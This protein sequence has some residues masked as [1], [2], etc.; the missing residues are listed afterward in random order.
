MK[1]KARQSTEDSYARITREHFE[2]ERKKKQEHLTRQFKH[3]LWYLD[4]TFVKNPSERE[5]NHRDW[6]FIWPKE[7]DFAELDDLVF[8]LAYSL[9]KKKKLRHEEAYS[10]VDEHWPSL[11]LD[12]FLLRF[13]KRVS[14]LRLD[15]PPPNAAYEHLKSIK[16]LASGKSKNSACA[17]DFLSIHRKLRNGTTSLSQ[18]TWGR[19]RDVLNK[20]GSQSI[21]LENHLIPFPPNSD[22]ECYTKY[23]ELE[24]GLLLWENAFHQWKDKTETRKPFYDWVERNDRRDID[25]SIRS[26]EERRAKAR[27]RKKRQRFREKL[28]QIRVTG[29]WT[30]S[31]AD[32]MP[33]GS[34]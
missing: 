34:R 13:A 21:C 1:K 31:L 17:K 6:P 25:L 16:K 9:R 11:R 20:P 32:L 29:E 26:E 23:L 12:K 19:Y 22:I 15:P 3:L 30:D 33:P 24:R 2:Q 4:E 7:V 10:L 8:R 14:G 28:A 5:P 27:K 18:I